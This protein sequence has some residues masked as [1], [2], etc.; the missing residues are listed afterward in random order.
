LSKQA[1]AEQLGSAVLAARAVASC[2]AS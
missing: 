2:T 1:K